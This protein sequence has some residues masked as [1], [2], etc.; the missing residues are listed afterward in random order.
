MAQLHVYSRGAVFVWEAEGSTEAPGA[1][2]AAPE[3][4]FVVYSRNRVFDWGAPKAV[5]SG[6]SDVT[7]DL[8]ATE[9]QDTAAFSGLVLIVG[10]LS[11]TESQDTASFSGASSV[12]GDLAATEAQD[13]AAF[14]GVVLILGDLAATEAQD[15][16]A[17]FGAGVGPVGDLAATESQDTAAFTGTIFIYGETESVWYFPMRL[18]A[19]SSSSTVD[20]TQDLENL[21]S[22]LPSQRQQVTNPDGTMNAAW[23]RFFDFFVNVFAGG[24]SAPTMADVQAAIENA[25]SELQTQ[26]QTTALIAAQS[27]TNA[28]ALAATVEVVQNNALTGASSIP[29]VSRTYLEP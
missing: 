5:V 13:S 1:G 17:F 3:S 6:G 23:Y 28:E 19:Q 27:Q 16:A 8:A 24:P 29:S 9:A 7:G 4:Q 12:S 26:Q 11:A 25:L 21:R 15:E 2:T 22:L 18:F 10:S 14:A 20:A